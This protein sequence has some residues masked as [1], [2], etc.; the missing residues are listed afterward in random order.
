M[1]QGENLVCQTVCQSAL[2]QTECFIEITGVWITSTWPPYSWS[3]T[4]PHKTCARVRYLLT[5]SL[6]LSCICIVVWVGVILVTVW[7]EAVRILK[8]HANNWCLLK[9]YAWLCLLKW[10]HRFCVKFFVT[11][12]RTLSLSLSLSLSPPPP[13]LSLSI[14]PSLSPSLFVSERERGRKQHPLTILV[15]HKVMLSSTIHVF[16]H[17]YTH[18]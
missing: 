10:Q 18:T 3:K 12:D 7:S 15:Y 9:L 17:T 16:T 8:V 13:S 2:L 14:S 11:W 1:Q 4:W 5:I 6:Q